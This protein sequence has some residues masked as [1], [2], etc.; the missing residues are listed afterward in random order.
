MEH[1]TTALSEMMKKLKRRQFYVC[2]TR[3]AETATH[4]MLGERLLEHLQWVC[5]LEESGVLLAA[6]TCAF[7]SG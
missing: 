3:L 7:F 4:A 2:H 1:P 5:G 6:G